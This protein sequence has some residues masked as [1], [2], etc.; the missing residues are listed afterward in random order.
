MQN[1]LIF[2]HARTSD[3]TLLQLQTGA[4]SARRYLYY[5][6]RVYPYRH[7][8]H[9]TAAQLISILVRWVLSCLQI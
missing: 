3:S 4:M 1:L 5:D 7:C 9:P 6:P 8:G 2:R